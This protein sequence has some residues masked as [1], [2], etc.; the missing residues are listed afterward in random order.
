MPVTLQKYQS[1]EEMYDNYSTVAKEIEFEGHV[2]RFKGTM[3]NHDHSIH[4]Y[5]CVSEQHYIRVHLQFNVPFLI[6][7]FYS[8]NEVTVDAVRRAS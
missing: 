5:H 3:R 8:V 7:A 1:R 6:E 2:Y 4:L